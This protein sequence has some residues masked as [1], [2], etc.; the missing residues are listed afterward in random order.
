MHERPALYRLFFRGGLSFK[1]YDFRELTEAFCVVEEW[2]AVIE[3]GDVIF[4]DLTVKIFEILDF[5]FLVVR[6]DFFLVE[7]CLW[8]VGLV[9]LIGGVSVG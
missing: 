2:F 4:F 9:W 5:Y 6:V 1:L 8:E 3:D 7:S